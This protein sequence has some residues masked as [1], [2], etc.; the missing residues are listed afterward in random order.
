MEAEAEAGDGAQAGAL[1]PAGGAPGEPASG[2]F[3][4]PPLAAR[5]TAVAM[6]TLNDPL[7]AGR[8]DGA[9]APTA[10]QP[11]HAAVVALRPSRSAVA[12]KPARLRDQGHLRF[13]AGEPCLVCGRSPADPHHLRYLQLRAL[14]RKVSDEFA[15][16]LCRGHHHELHR[17]GDERQWW[18]ERNLDPESVAL[19]LWRRSHGDPSS[20]S[21]QEPTA[22]APSAEPISI[23]RAP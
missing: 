9:P 17:T 13:V 21:P 23:D 6:T 5:E 19:A 10:R 11:A 22:A 12:L 14:G 8:S 4:A 18:R 16:P 20:E 15:V 2:S 1:R 3:A 7:A